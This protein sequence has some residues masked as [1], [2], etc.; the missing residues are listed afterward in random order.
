[1]EDR[2]SMDIEKIMSGSDAYLILQKDNPEE[3]ELEEAV[4]TI[5]LELAKEHEKGNVRYAHE[6]SGY[7]EM[8]ED[9]LEKVIVDIYKE[10]GFSHGKWIAKF[11]RG[12]QLYNNYISM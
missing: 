11:L 7:V 3:K 1:M 5:L 2:I 8:H 10:A 12:Y 4:I 6:L 9:I